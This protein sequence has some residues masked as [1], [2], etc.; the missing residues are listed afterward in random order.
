MRNPTGDEIVGRL[1]AII[2]DGF[3]RSLG[4]LERAGAVNTK[5]LF[6]KA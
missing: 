6:Q 5:S 4:A 2:S 3:N 1:V